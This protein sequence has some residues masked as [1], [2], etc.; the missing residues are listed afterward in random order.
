MKDKINGEMLMVGFEGVKI[1][2]EIRRYILRRKV[3]AVILFGRN[4]IN[5]SQVGELCAQLQELR[6]EVA[7]DP[8][9]IAVDQE[10][11]TVVRLRDGVTIFP[12]NLALG[13]AGSVEDAYYQGRITGRELFGQGINMN[14]APVLDLYSDQGSRSLGLRSLGGDPEDVSGLGLAL[15]RGMQD[16]GIISTAKHFPGKGSARVDSHEELPVI[17]DSLPDLKGKDIRPFQSAILAGVKAIMTSHAAYPSFEDGAILPGTISRNLMT[18]LLRDEL[19]FSGILISDDLGMG[20]LRSRDLPEVRAMKALRAGVD[21]LLLC[22]DPLVREKVFAAL[23]SVWNSD[24]EMRERME[25]SRA[26]IALVKS[27]LNL[28]S[29]NRI[30][31]SDPEGSKL[32]LRIARRGISLYKSSGGQIPLASGNRLL[33]I[34]FQPEMTVEVE[35][36]GMT[37]DDPAE[38]LKSPGFQPEIVNIALQPGEAEGIKILNDLPGNIPVLIAAYDAYRHSG[39]KKLINSILER[40][41][42]AILAVTRDPRDAE[43][44]PL[45]RTII[46]TRG[47]TA[48]S[49]RGLAEVLAGILI[50]PGEK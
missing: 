43:L 14:L 20:A 44:F 7:D 4:I 48:P 6:R 19:N 21:I 22:H 31:E 24:R 13:F 1:N 36:T 50:S 38:H 25:E 45:A 30:P 41:P 10:G 35:G 5:S 2:D 26:R 46:I 34:R 39:Q 17:K 8:L 29:P 33:M 11:G 40:L 47:Y 23:L 37:A 32:S 9:L 3:G 16:E 12:G 15:I 42:D 28:Q 49:L 18:G 27:W